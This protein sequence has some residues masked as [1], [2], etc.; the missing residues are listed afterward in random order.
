MQKVNSSWSR[1]V[2]AFIAVLTIAGSGIVF[3]A[4]PKAGYPAPKFAVIIGSATPAV[5]T[6]TPYTLDVTF[7]DGSTAAF[8]TQAS[9][10]RVAGAAGSFSANNFTPS[11]A[12]RVEI[13]GSYS[14]SGVT[15]SSTRIVTAM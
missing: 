7:V 1:M 8:T 2:M 14:S 3:A 11:A 5:G 13:M 12:G 4:G 6:S 15:V 10:S 9:W